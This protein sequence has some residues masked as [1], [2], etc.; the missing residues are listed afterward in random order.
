VQF[1][2]NYE[3]GG[4]RSVL[5]GDTGSETFLSEMIGA[6]SFP[7]R[8]LSIESLFEYGSRAGDW[9]V[10]RLFERAG[11]PP[12]IFAVARALERNTEAAFR[13]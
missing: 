5:D 1:V 12:T 11:L 2:L 6:E 7:S 13:T 10:L 4:G 9:W 3:D 8:H